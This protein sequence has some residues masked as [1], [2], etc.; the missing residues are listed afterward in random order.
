LL[1]MTESGIPDENYRFHVPGWVSLLLNLKAVADHGIDLRN[2][3]PAASWD[4]GFVDV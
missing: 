4:A 1:A 2:D 3:D